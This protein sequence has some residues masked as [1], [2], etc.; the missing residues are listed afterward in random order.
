MKN[1]IVTSL[2]GF[3][4]LGIFLVLNGCSD[5]TK[6]SAT[7]EL[8]E[9]VYPSD[10]TPFFKHW[11]LIL[12]DGSNAGDATDF[13]HKDFFYTTKDGET[14]WVVYK[15]P[16][17]GDTHGTSRNTRTELAQTKKMVCLNRC[18][19]NSYA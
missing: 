5:S 9:T 10:V 7:I 16:N 18:K 3:L 6:K 13:E 4:L 1:K 14:N 19:I 15:A 8:Q 2:S 11:K 12:G 17:Q